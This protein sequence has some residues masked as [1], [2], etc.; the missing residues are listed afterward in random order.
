M[1]YGLSSLIVTLVWVGM[2]LRVYHETMLER[3][4]SATVMGR[5]S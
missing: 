3:R 1:S 5:D 2:L 4:G